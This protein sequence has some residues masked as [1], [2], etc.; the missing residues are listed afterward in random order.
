MDTDQIISQWLETKRN[1]GTRAGYARDVADFQ[2][3]VDK[4]ALAE[5]TLDDLL[6]WSA[7]LEATA[8]A[9]THQRKLSAVRSLFQFAYIRRHLADNISALVACPKPKDSLGE[10]LVDL[11]VI[12]K[13]IEAAK[14]NPRDALLVRCMYVTAGRISEVL[15]LRWRDLQERES[16]GQVCFYGKG[17]KTRYVK[18]PAPL[19]AELM[20]VKGEAGP[21]DQVFTICRQHVWRIIK[22][23]ASKACVTADI[24]PHWFRHAHA[25]HALEKQATLAQVR[26]T[27][28]HSD[29]K[30]TSRYLHAKPDESSSEFLDI[31]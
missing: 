3:F 30:T 12:K 9:A 21:D 14:E 28:G 22:K 11:E 8:E 29:I 15:S 4:D 24:S 17:K 27:L 7:H 25:S 13:I 18:V 6:R 5:V 31:C 20:A 16:G 23:L 1:P 26:D 10:K 19:W 2:A